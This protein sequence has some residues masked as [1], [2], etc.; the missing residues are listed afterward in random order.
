[1]GGDLLKK[2]GKKQK[3]PDELCKKREHQ[4]LLLEKNLPS[5]S[6]LELSDSEVSSTEEFD[7]YHDQLPQEKFSLLMKLIE[8]KKISQIKKLLRYSENDS[9]VANSNNAAL[10]R[11]TGAGLYQV[12]ELLLR[13]KAVFEKN[14]F[15]I[16]ESRL[17]FS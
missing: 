15:Q 7:E 5:M 12:V 10:L 8:E 13:N 2:A 9:W 4:L 11:A 14:L 6:Y 17:S 1:M 16:L 3:T